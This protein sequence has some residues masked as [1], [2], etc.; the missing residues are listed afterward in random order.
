MSQVEENQKTIERY[1]QAGQ[2]WPATTM[3]I[4]RWATSNGLWRISRER[5][6]RQCADQMGEAMRQEY[7]TDPQGRRVRMKHVAPYPSEKGG[8][9]LLFKW[10]DM[11]TRNHEH[12]EVSF[13]HRRQEIF[14]DCRQLKTDSDSYNENFR[15]P[16]KRPVNGVF[17]FTY[18]LAEEELGSQEEPTPVP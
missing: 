5:M 11:R 17:D 7:A 2:P 1:R 8:Q 9:R 14:G 3:D 6:L 18:D 15:P 4:A 12:M 16:D 13:A 10:E